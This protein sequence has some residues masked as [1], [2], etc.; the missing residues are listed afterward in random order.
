MIWTERLVW[1]LG[2]I[3]LAA[4]AHRERMKREFFALALVSAH[5]WVDEIIEALQDPDESQGNERTDR[6]VAQFRSHGRTGSDQ[7]EDLPC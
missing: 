2:L 7:P 1:L 3:A 6:L 4:I 5:Q